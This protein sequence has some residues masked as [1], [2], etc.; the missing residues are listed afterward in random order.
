MKT[1]EALSYLIAKALDSGYDMYAVNCFR[2]ELRERLNEMPDTDKDTL[3]ELFEEI[4]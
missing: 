2:F 3:D 1:D 4:F